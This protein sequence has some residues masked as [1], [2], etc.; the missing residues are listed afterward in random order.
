LAYHL[1]HGFQSA[2]QTLGLYHKKYTPIIKKIGTI[3]AIIIP[4]LFA[5]MPIVMYLGI[6]K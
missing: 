1:M 6:V 2:F 3:Y 4:L 5:L